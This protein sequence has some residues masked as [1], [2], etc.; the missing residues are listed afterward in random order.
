MSSCGRLAGE[1]EAGEM[2]SGW[3]M[4]NSVYRLYPDVRIRCDVFSISTDLD[5]NVHKCVTDAATL[6]L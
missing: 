1:H 2:R 5:D 6:K 3:C 4:L